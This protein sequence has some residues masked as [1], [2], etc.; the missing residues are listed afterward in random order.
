MFAPGDGRVTRRS[1]LAETLAAAHRANSLFDTS[2]PIVYAVFGCDFHS[3]LQNN[4]ILQDNA[5]TALVS[6]ALK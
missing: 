3:H 4:Q 1:V 6:E 2:L 5:L